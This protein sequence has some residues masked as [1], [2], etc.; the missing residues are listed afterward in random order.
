VQYNVY[1]ELV[2]AYGFRVTQTGRAATNNLPA[3]ATPARLISGV[4]Q[5]ERIG[6]S[7]A[8]L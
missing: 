1:N 5:L 3:Q 6:F 7:L 2:E 4:A 8:Y